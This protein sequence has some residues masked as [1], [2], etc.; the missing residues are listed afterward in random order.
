MQVRILEYRDFANQSKSSSLA[1]ALQ[2]GITS[3]VGGSK[4]Q[5]NPTQQYNR[6]L[7]EL[8]ADN[9][10]L[11]ASN[12]PTFNLEQDLKAPAGSPVPRPIK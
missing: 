9:T 8:K 6:A 11:A 5:A 2:S 7:A 1:R 4:D 3:I 10:K 12:C